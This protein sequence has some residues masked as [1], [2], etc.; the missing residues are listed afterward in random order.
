M[1][2][3]SFTVLNNYK[4]PMAQ[5][6][7]KQFGKEL[8]F[9]DFRERKPIQTLAAGL[10]PLECRWSLKE[11][12][13]HGFTNCALDDSIWVWE[14]EG[15]AERAPHQEH[16]LRDQT[17]EQLGDCVEQPLGGQAAGWRLAE[18]VPR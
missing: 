6:D 18:S 4:K 1:V 5:M 15:A 2:T 12:A 3:S 16:R 11:R 13:N 17:V 14:G 8:T 7:F 10:A 9:W